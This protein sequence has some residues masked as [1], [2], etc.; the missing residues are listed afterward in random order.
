MKKKSKKFSGLFTHWYLHYFCISGI[1]Y[2]IVMM[3]GGG[4]R[5]PVFNL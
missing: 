5:T 1:K 2:P 4:G 3:S